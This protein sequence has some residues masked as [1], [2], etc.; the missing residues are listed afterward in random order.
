MLLDVRPYRFGY[1]QAATDSFRQSSFFSLPRGWILGPEKQE[2]EMTRESVPRRGGL[3]SGIQA[4][5]L[6]DT[7]QDITEA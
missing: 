6:R 1:A 2:G 3:S 4:L 5:Q 7:L